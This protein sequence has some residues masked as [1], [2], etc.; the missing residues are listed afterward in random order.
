MSLSYLPSLGIGGQAAT[1]LLLLLFIGRRITKGEELVLDYGDK[2]WGIIARS[3]MIEQRAYAHQALQREAALKQALQAKVAA[4]AISQQQLC[5][6]ML[7]YVI[8][9]TR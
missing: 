7:C 6:V 9:L 5:Y 8:T 3:L 4:G 1:S 2:Y